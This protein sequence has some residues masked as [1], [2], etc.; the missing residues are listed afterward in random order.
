MSDYPQFVAPYLAKQMN[1]AIPM[2]LTE[3]CRLA[4]VSRA[5]FYR[6]RSASALLTSI[7]PHG[8]E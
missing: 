2:P 6:W 7:A 1:L 8:A 4:K 5:G 3:L